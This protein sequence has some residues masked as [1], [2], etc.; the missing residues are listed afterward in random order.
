MCYSEGFGNEQI[1]AVPQKILFSWEWIKWLLTDFYF[2]HLVLALRKH[3]DTYLKKFYIS[4]ISTEVHLQ[5][6]IMGVA[7]MV[8]IINGFLWKD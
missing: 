5:T 6:P 8:A 2:K 3:L 1:I 7:A 4:F